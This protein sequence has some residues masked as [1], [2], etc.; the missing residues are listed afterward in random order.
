L[1]KKSVLCT[2]RYIVV[3]KYF[4]LMLLANLASFQLL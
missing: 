2:L 1:E 3:E 4:Y